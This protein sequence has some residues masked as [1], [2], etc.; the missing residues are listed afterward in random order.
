[1]CE[2]A[3]E[4]K[5]IVTNEVC[6]WM[7][8]CNKRQIYKPSRHMPQNCNI[9]ARV[10]VPKGYYK[11]RMERKGYLYV[12]IDNCTYK[13]KNPFDDIPLYVKA[14]KLKSGEWRLRK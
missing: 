11:V 5:C 13:I 4:N 10:E 3:K 7:Y 9:K 2:Y 12:D 6:P 1:M 14:T 8:W